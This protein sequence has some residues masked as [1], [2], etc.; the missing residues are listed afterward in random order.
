[1]PLFIEIRK[2]FR[3]NLQGLS[4]S[5]PYVLCD[6]RPKVRDSALR[7]SVRISDGYGGYPLMR[8]L[9]VYLFRRDGRFEDEVRALVDQAFFL[10]QEYER[11]RVERLSKKKK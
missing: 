3:E 1:M 5:A 10:G 2:P 7:R 6:Y 9:L 4:R 11:E 8:G